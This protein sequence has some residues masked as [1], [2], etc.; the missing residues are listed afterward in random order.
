MNLLISRMKE[1]SKIKRA[2]NG[3]SFVLENNN[4]YFNN[5]SFSLSFADCGLSKFKSSFRKVHI[6]SSEKNIILLK[7]GSFH[8]TP[9]KT[10]LLGENN[11]FYF[12]KNLDNYNDVKRRILS[13]SSSLGFEIMR[14]EFLDNH[15][16]LISNIV[17]GKQFKDE[18]H[19]SKLMT[20]LFSLYNAERKD[21]GERLIDG[22]DGHVLFMVQHGDC[23]L[24]N[25]FWSSNSFSLIDLDDINYYPFFYDIFYLFLSFYHEKAF[26]IFRSEKFRND[27]ELAAKKHNIA[28]QNI[29]DKYLSA[30][31]YYWVNQMKSDTKFFDIFFYVRWFLN[32]DLTGFPSV[33]AA[34]EKYKENLNLYRIK[35]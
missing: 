15:A 30:Y 24:G 20:N 6:S 3:A 2:L 13:L 26:D 7:K 35:K 17:E 14:S 16:L 8:L 25:V 11:A 5:N 9:Y 21:V 12:F 23:H 33:V 29:V 1:I 28:D 18:G 22:V 32:A 19:L 10:I 31:L 4:Y 27:V 34:I